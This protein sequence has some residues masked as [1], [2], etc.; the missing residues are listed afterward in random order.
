MKTLIL[1]DVHNRHELVEKIIKS[2][3]PDQTIFLGDYFDDFGDDPHII[4][5]TA[6]WF[7]YSV[8]QKNRIHIC[9]NHDIHYWFADNPH[10]RCSGYDQFKSIAV[11]DI[12]QLK[13]WEKLVF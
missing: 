6:H 9:G 12:V 2:V 8:N 10:V 11:N 1:P 13:D 3:K 7:T 4:A 5:E